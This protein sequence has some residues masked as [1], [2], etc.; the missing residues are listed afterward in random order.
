MYTF[1]IDSILIILGL[2]FAIWLAYK[3]FKSKYMGI[4]ERAEIYFRQVGDGV[5]EQIIDWEIKALTDGVNTYILHP[6]W[7]GSE[8]DFDVFAYSDGRQLGVAKL[9]PD[10]PNSVYMVVFDA[11]EKGESKKFTVK[12]K[13]LLDSKG[14]MDRLLLFST[15]E[16]ECQKLTLKV[17]CFPM[18]VF[19]NVIDKHTDTRSIK[20]FPQPLNSVQTNSDKGRMWYN[21]T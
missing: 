13:N 12:Y 17:G 6:S 8:K 16:K 5:Y 19:K 7:T 20:G 15:S 14:S 1:T 3:Y 2:E 9:H 10:D 18:F 21:G 11:M 4:D